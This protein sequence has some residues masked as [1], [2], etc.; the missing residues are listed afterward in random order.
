LL[1]REDAA[2]S[3]LLLEGL[4]RKP[5]PLVAQ[6]Y[7]L[8][9][10]LGR[11]PAQ[12]L[13][14][15]RHI[16]DECAPLHQ[17]LVPQALDN[18]RV[19]STIVCSED[20]DPSWFH[21]VLLKPHLEPADCLDMMVS[22]WAASPNRKVDLVVLRHRPHPPF[23]SS[24]R[25]LASLMLRGAGPLVDREIFRAAQILDEYELTERQKEVLHQLLCGD[26]EREIARE[27]HRSLN[28]IHSHVKQI[29]RT[30][31]VRSRGELMAIF[32]DRR[33]LELCRE[34]DK[35]H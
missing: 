14:D 5:A 29:Y 20:S 12:N 4:D 27:L 21:D 16:S 22:A 3:F 15:A 1:N 6:R 35:G 30:F 34:S 19:P 13:K 23:G 26:S 11:S 18:L 28:T 25:R 17:L 2:C 32:V 31:D 8:P 10:P 24:D 33:V 7:H 9:A